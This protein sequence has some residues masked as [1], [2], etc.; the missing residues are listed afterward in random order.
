MATRKPKNLDSMPWSKIVLP[1]ERSKTNAPS[2]DNVSCYILHTY[3]SRKCPHPLSLLLIPISPPWATDLVYHCK[4]CLTINRLLCQNWPN[5]AFQKSVYR[6][7]VEG[8]HKDPNVECLKVVDDVSQE[9]VGYL[10][11]SRKGPAA[12]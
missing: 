2:L 3:L 6:S 10:A 11:L 8:A 12:E 9:I 7:T 5:E 1:H 4:L